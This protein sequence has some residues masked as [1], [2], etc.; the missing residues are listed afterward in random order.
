MQKNG[1]CKLNL[2]D[3]PLRPRPFHQSLCSLSKAAA[4]AA[5]AVILLPLRGGMTHAAQELGGQG[6]GRGQSL[7]MYDAAQFATDHARTHTHTH[8]LIACSSSS[9]P[10]CGPIQ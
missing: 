10:S 5:A 2:C 8:V 7:R 6:S 3:P 1:G 4:A 9:L